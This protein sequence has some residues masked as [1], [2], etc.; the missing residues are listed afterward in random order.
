MTNSCS[1]TVSCG[2]IGTPN[3]I[4]NSDFTGFLGV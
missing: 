1:K 2:K 4:F 3:P